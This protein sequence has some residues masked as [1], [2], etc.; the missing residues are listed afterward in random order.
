MN[1]AQSIMLVS[2]LSSA[3]QAPT[4]DSRIVKDR[5]QATFNSV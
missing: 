2:P 4:D 1:T 5:K 3:W